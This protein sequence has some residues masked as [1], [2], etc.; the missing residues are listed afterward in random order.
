MKSYLLGAG[1]K[2]NVI[3]FEDTLVACRLIS[4]ASDKSF[5]IISV[6]PSTN[7]KVKIKW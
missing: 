3:L 5:S 6:L 4:G 1:S 7:V 2:V